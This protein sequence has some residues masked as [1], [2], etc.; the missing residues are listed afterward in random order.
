MCRI[1][2]VS[3]IEIGSMCLVLFGHIICGFML[4]V[5]KVASFERMSIRF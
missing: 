2:F 1:H 3:I 4:S 5:V